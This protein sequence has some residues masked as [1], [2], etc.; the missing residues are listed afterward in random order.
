MGFLTK[1]IKETYYCEDYFFQFFKGI[2]L[3]GILISFFFHAAHLWIKQ[4]CLQGAERLRKW[5]E[6]LLT[7]SV[8]R[9]PEGSALVISNSA[10]W[11]FFL[12]ERN[13]S[14]EWHL[15]SARWCLWKQ[16]TVLQLVLLMQHLEEEITFRN[17]YKPLNRVIN[18]WNV[19]D[20][21]LPNQQA[22]L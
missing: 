5:K 17:V 3:L 7:C 16:S 9:G 10:C 1:I 13:L 6:L 15:S 12:T 2:F 21:T 22:P 4:V 18:R 19:A 8:L 11:M 14:E 20:S